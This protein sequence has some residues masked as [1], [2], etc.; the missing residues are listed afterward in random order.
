MTQSIRHRAFFCY[1]A[2][3]KIKIVTGVKKKHVQFFHCPSL[4]AVVVAFK[5]YLKYKSKPTKTNK[6]KKMMEYKRK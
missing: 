1:Q 3:P 6:F 2:F 5:Q 4:W